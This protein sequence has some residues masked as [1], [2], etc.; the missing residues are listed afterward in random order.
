MIAVGG[1]FAVV[2]H[3]EYAARYWPVER[4][5][6][7]DPKRFEDEFRQAMRAVAGTGRA[8]EL[9]I[10]GP[11]RGSLSGGTRRADG[12]SPSQAMRT[13][14]TGWP[15]TSTRRWRWP[16]TSRPPPTGFLDRLIKRSGPS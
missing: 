9:N 15:A 11:N 12:R 14:L 13:L 3:I 6:P 5:G 4:E 1:T 16:N 8:L 7:F 2:T 10:G